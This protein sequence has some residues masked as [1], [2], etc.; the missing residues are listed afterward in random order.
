MTKKNKKQ[1]N[2]RRPDRRLHRVESL[3]D[4][5]LMA[6]D[7]TLNN[8]LLTIDGDATDNHI[9]VQQE[10]RQLDYGFHG[11]GLRSSRFR[12]T[13]PLRV[14]TVIKSHMEPNGTPVEYG[15]ET[16]SSAIHQVHFFGHGG[17]DFFDNQTHIPTVAYGGFGDDTLR[18]GSSHDTLFGYER[19]MMNSGMLA[20][21]VRNLFQN[22]RSMFQVVSDGNDL[23]IGNEGNDRLHGGYGMDSLHGN[24]GDDA[25]FGGAGNDRIFGGDGRDLL[26]GLGGNDHI[27]GGLENDRIY[28]GHGHDELFGGFGNDI[29]FGNHGHDRMSGESGNDALFGG[30]GNDRLDGGVGNDDLDG[31]A[32]NDQ[33]MGRAGHDWLFGGTGN[34]TLRGGTGHD[35]L[36]GEGGN[37]RLYGGSGNDE[38]RGGSGN[39]GLFGGRGRDHLVGSQGADR[40]L[41]Q[42]EQLD[43]TDRISRSDAVI[44]FE[45]S[46]SG[47]V[48]EFVFTAGNWTDAEIET[49]DEAFDVL[50]HRTGNTNLLKDSD[51]DSL[52]FQRIGQCGC[53]VAGFNSEGWFGG[54]TIAMADGSFDR[55]KAWTHQVVFHEIGHNWE[56]ENPNWTE[57][58]DLS[59]WERSIPMWNWLVDTNVKQRSTDEGWWHR[60][61]AR[62]ARDYGKT[63][64]REDFATTFALHFMTEAGEGYLGATNGMSN[65]ALSNHISTKINFMERFVDSLA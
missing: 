41:L 54:P 5:R 43:T 9:V 27:R 46:Q 51:G 1:R 59:G 36:H 30:A 45:N 31:E 18:G 38:L 37:D 44:H 56:N 26:S 64:P 39:D 15:R 17:D 23:L 13:R 52:L 21:P 49:V 40:F 48:G 55:S 19:P 57:W 6:A 63:N 28:G 62:F 60:R 50:H 61:N 2:V 35:E 16:F 34:D 33:L 7:V 58:K 12:A 22:Q 3:E 8:G 20:G 47:R 65:A 24:A 32:G 10:L 29:L 4:R 42:N 53:N 14:T 11:F 25:I